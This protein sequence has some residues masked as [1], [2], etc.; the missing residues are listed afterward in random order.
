MTFTSIDRRPRPA[1]GAR[2]VV[3]CALELVPIVG[4]LVFVNAAHLPYV[5]LPLVFVSGFG[6]LVMRQWLL[7]A[8]FALG[9]AALV[10]VPIVVFI[11]VATCDDC[12][13]QFGAAFTLWFLALFVQP[14][15]S[16][17]AVARFAQTHP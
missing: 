2:V 7:A 9:R 10:V 16:A 5:W 8:L 15:L 3:A 14:V 12:S 1:H 13:G 6:W 17:A 11:Q 4:G